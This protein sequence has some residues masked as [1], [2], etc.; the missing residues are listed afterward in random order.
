MNISND[1]LQTGIK[2][3]SS[4][5][6]IVLTTTFILSGLIL[7][8]PNS[9]KY[10]LSAE[11]LSKKTYAEKVNLI[12]IRDIRDIKDIKEKTKK[13]IPRSKIL[14]IVELSKNQQL[15]KHLKNKD[16]TIVLISDNYKHALLNLTILK[17]LNYTNVHILENGINGW[18]EAGFPL[19]ENK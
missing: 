6:N 5:Y 15:N 12:D 13:S 9:K 16:E 4:P 1:M 19:V 7:F 14:N 2:F 3:F 8:M 11:S 10:S 17:K 18:V